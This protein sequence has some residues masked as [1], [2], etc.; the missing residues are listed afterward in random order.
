M[1]TTHTPPGSC[2]SLALDGDG[3]G[4]GLPEMRGRGLSVTRRGL[5]W[6]PYL[7]DRKESVS[8]SHSGQPRQ[9][10]HDGTR[11]SVARRLSCSVI[12]PVL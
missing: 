4:D 8:I 12:A 7:H 1:S 9:R 5:G 11:Y 3:I 6:C 10:L 2:V